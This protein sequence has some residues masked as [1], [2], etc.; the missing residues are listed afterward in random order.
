M[1]L[2]PFGRT[3][4]KMAI[5]VLSLWCVMAVVGLI[6][7]VAAHIF[8]WEDVIEDGPD[9]GIG[10]EDP[11]WESGNIRYEKVDML[12][13][14]QPENPIYYATED[15]RDYYGDTH[16]YSFI[17]STWNDGSK[18]EWCLLTPD[19]DYKYM[20]FKL[21]LRDETDN[22][23][24]GNITIY[25]DDTGVEL[26][27]SDEFG[28]EHSHFQNASV[29][30]EGIRRLRFVSDYV[31]TDNWLNSYSFLLTDGFICSDEAAY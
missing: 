6:L 14:D 8:G 17:L 31:G 5:A 19:G 25:D 28:R 22:T 15:D 24:Y 10:F 9:N 12:E 20:N 21:S 29:N 23:G 2:S 7:P 3:I 27:R 4:I 13:F 30:I 26:W 18:R 11:T 1:R 16:K